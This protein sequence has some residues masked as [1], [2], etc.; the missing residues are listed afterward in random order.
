MMIPI[1]KV[2]IRN[3]AIKNNK[4]IFL[5]NVVHGFLRSLF[6]APNNTQCLLVIIFNNI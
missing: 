3:A 6:L 5:V 4:N 2:I 1:I